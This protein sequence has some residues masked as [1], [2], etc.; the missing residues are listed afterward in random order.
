[1]LIGDAPEPA[2]EA[3]LKAI[4][5]RLGLTDAIIWTGWVPTIAAWNFLRHAEVA[6]SIVARGELFDCASPTKVV[7]YL[8]LGIP[9]VANDQPDQQSVLIE[10]GGGISVAM[11]AREISEAIL[12]ILRDP[13]LAEAMGNAG[14]RYIAAHRSYALI[15]DRVAHVYQKLWVDSPID[16]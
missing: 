7:E 9:V 8:A 4:A 11:N 16:H 3:W 2:D 12:K 5:A 10:S 6:V 13:S 15:G 1:L 14:P